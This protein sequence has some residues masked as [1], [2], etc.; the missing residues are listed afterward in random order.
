MAKLLYTT[1][2]NKDFGKMPFS[3]ALTTEE[4]AKNDYL[5]NGL[6]P[7]S[8][9]AM[10]AS[11]LK[12]AS[13]AAQKGQ[14]GSQSHQDAYAAVQDL[15]AGITP[16]W[17]GKTQKEMGDE[18]RGLAFDYDVGGKAYA[19]HPLHPPA[20]PVEYISGGGG[21]G[22]GIGSGGVFQNTAQQM[23]KIL[24]QGANLFH[25]AQGGSTMFDPWEQYR[26]TSQ[27]AGEKIAMDVFKQ[28]YAQTEAIAS[29]R[30]FHLT[31][32]G[33]VEYDDGSR[34]KRAWE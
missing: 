24:K 31:L 16:S 26:K 32:G 11:L 20:P 2:Y 3:P 29:G 17:M 8:S 25:K 23:E 19:A 27:K 33:D 22:V 21:G 1:A 13:N 10:Q 4:Y 28:K 12:P 9:V 30:P 7:P 6:I 5:S 18:E 14:S 15:K 34:T